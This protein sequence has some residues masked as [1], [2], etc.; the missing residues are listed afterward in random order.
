[1]P[2]PKNNYVLCRPAIREKM[3]CLGSEAMQSLQIHFLVVSVSP[4]RLVTTVPTGIG[5]HSNVKFW[6]RLSTTRTFDQGSWHRVW[7]ISRTEKTSFRARPEFNADNRNN[8]I[9]ESSCSGM[10]CEHL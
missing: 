6:A 10:R 2:K 7:R 8:Q 1:V 4:P 5:L 3:S 9:V